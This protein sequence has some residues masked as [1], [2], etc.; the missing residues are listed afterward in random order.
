MDMIFTYSDVICY[1]VNQD[2]PRSSLTV[3]VA[4]I[5]FTT[6][7]NVAKWQYMHINVV[8]M[9]H[10]YIYVPQLSPSPT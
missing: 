4:R 6:F 5:G 1:V 9:N 3:T 10:N 7:L 2:R 8:K